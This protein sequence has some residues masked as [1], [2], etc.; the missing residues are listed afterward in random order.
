MGLSNTNAKILNT[1]DERL[2]SMSE[3]D[4]N[5]PGRRRIFYRIGNQVDQYLSKAHL[6]AYYLLLCSSLDANLMER[7]RLLQVFDNL[8]DKLVNIHDFFY[9]YEFPHLDLRNIEQVR[10]QFG[11]RLNL[12]LHYLNLMQHLMIALL[13]KPHGQ[14]LPIPL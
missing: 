13:C 10:N 9:K 8:M 5:L 12:H 4:D 1:D 7:G 3:M 11:E 2:R 6:V 14:Q